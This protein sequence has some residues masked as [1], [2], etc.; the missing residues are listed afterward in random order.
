[1]IFTDYHMREGDGHY[2]LARIK[3]TPST[4]HIP[5]IVFSGRTLTKGER[6]CLQRD[7]RGRGEAAAFLT[8]PINTG[9]LLDE[10]RKHVQLPAQ[11]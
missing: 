9:A 2:L 3:G 1:M 4:Q 6:A 10:L 7:L 11:S 5:V 8:K